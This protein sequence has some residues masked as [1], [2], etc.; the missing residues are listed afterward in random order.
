MWSNKELSIRE[1]VGTFYMNN[2]QMEKSLIVKPE[3]SID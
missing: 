3:L 2:K 1:R